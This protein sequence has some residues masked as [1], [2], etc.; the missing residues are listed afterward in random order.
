MAAVTVGKKICG[1]M[2]GLFCIRYN[3]TL[4]QKTIACLIYYFGRN[5]M[6]L[7]LGIKWNIVLSCSFEPCL[8]ERILCAVTLGFSM[9]RILEYMTVLCYV[10]HVYFTIM[11]VHRVISVREFREYKYTDTQYAAAQY[12]ETGNFLQ[13]PV[14][15]TKYTCFWLIGY[16][17]LKFSQYTLHDSKSRLIPLLTG[18][19]DNVSWTC[20]YGE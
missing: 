15:N 18:P 1:Q 10:L 9:E 4:I 17:L 19:K 3:I 6:R 7:S 12:T 20:T 2:E 16:T 14:N 13:Y 8:M 11:F 5:L